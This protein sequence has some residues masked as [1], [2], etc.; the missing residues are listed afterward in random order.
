MEPQMPVS[1]YWCETMRVGRMS[2]RLKERRE[3][4]ISLGS[5]SMIQAA[6]LLSTEPEQLSN[7][8]TGH[9]IAM[10]QLTRCP[11]W[12]VRVEVSPR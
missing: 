6:E 9:E 4:N 10:P 1:N 8:A 7:I 3:A 5:S 12:P 11:Q 2:E